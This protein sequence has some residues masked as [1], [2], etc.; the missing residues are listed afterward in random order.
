[1]RHR[2][3]LPLLLFCLLWGNSSLRA[4]TDKSEG[5][6]IV[7]PAGSSK[8][9]VSLLATQ[10]RPS[11]RQIDYQQREMLG[12]IHIGMNTFTG[13]EW[14]TGQESPKLFNPAELDAEEWV[15]T[16]KEA[17]ITGVILVAKHH[18]G[19]CV[20]PSKYTTH[21]VANAPWRDGKGDLVK[22]VADACRKYDMKLCLY[23]SPWDMH[24]ATYGTEDYNDYYIHQLEELLTQYG[25]VY[26]LWFDGAGTQEAVSG[27]NMPFQWERIFQRAR[28][29]QPDV[30]LSG[31]APDVRWVGNEKGKGRA[32]EW[33][34][35]GVNED[36]RLFGALKDY[37]H[38]LSDLGSVEDLMTKKRLVWYPSRGGLPLRKGWF[39]NVADDESIKSLDYLIDSYFSTVGQNSNLLPNLSPDPSGRIPLRDAERLVAFGR[40]IQDMKRVDYAQGALGTPDSEWENCTP[41]ALT[42]ES[43]FTSWNTADGVTQATATLQLNQT[44]T[45]NVVRLQ[46]NVRDFGQ[47]VE[48]FAID[49]WQNGQW[50]EIAD[51]TTIGFRRMLRLPAPVTTQKLRIRILDARL[52]VSL[53]SISCFLLPEIPDESPTASLAATTNKVDCRLSLRGMKGYRLEYLTDAEDNTLWRGKI[54]KKNATF[55]F[56]L[57]NKAASNGIVYVPGTLPKGHIEHYAVYVSDDGKTWDGPVVSGRFGNI[58]NNPVEQRITFQETKKRFVKLEVRKTVSDSREIEIA[59]LRLIHDLK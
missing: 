18:D 12:F 36:S 25:P 39:Y 58:E 53:G 21:S 19:F 24:E 54:T 55:V 23:L 40:I 49:A 32:T 35:Q 30:I 11:Y 59:D 4:Q 31:N 7:I 1:M 15:K 13:Q 29:L 48:R 6:S 38:T 22:E 20:W 45:F 27:K 56:E 33:C 42:D 3:I 44:A 50:A 47:R 34:V 14:G 9:Q 8:E 57:D 5:I 2:F 43:L 26:L 51:G 10:I 16:F 41:E 17:G 46:E 52:S 37:D 28:E